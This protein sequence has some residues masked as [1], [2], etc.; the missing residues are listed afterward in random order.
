LGNRP[1]DDSLEVVPP[2]DTDLLSLLFFIGR[3]NL[4]QGSGI[5][6]QTLI[7]PRLTARLQGPMMSESMEPYRPAENL[8]PPPNWLR[9]FLQGKTRVVMAWVFF[10]WVGWESRSAPAVPGVILC[11]LGATLRYWASGHLRK[12]ARPAVGGP[13]AHTRNP[14][15]LGTYVMAVGTAWAAGNWILLAAATVLF[16]FVYHFI[17]LDEETKL[18]KI[19]GQPYLAYVGLVPRFF[20]RPLPASW[21]RLQVVNPDESHRHFSHSLAHKNK[22]YEAYLSFLGLIGWVWLCSWLWSLT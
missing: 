9:G 4:R 2:P 8:A 1:L 20:P 19:F 13:Y 12:D 10:L 3:D 7:G 6:N 15:Y 5:L 17:I 16:A 11:F 14:L 22:A 21:N 18:K